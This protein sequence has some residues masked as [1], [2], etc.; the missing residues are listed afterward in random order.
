M[1]K[2]MRTDH[3][4]H[5]ELAGSLC[6][7]N[8][9]PVHLPP[10]QAGSGWCRQSGWQGRGCSSDFLRLVSC[11]PLLCYQQ[12]PCRPPSLQ[13]SPVASPT[14]VLVFSHSSNS[15]WKH[16][17]HESCPVEL[18]VMMQSPSVVSTG[19]L[20]L[21]SSSILKC[22]ECDPRSDIHILLFN[23]ILF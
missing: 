2:A 10:G 18:S 12:S 23:F 16:T 14:P 20:G 13:A 17:S 15:L 21:L 9:D 4:V 5:K 6:G 22:E 11:L 8:R 1:C 19:C 7:Q 3:D